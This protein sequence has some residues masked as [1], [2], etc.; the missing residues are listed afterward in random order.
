MFQLLAEQE[1]V[2][3]IINVRWRRDRKK[4]PDDVDLTFGFFAKR[5]F[6]SIDFLPYDFF[7]AIVFSLIPKW[8]LLSLK[9]KISPIK[10][11]DKQP[12]IR[13]KLSLTVAYLEVIDVFVAK[14]VFL[15]MQFFADATLANV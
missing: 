15:T 6:L 1:T 11:S 5:K 3:L 7:R 10:A 9:P 8:R 13:R 14:I 2:A 4:L 12:E